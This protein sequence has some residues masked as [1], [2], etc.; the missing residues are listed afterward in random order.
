MTDEEAFEELGKVMK[1]AKDDWAI[2][3]NERW[4]KYMKIYFNSMPYPNWCGYEWNSTGGNN[5]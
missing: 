4:N 1:Y 2:K 3:L 5:E